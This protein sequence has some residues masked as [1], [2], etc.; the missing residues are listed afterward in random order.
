MKS[1]PILLAVLAALPLGA[2]AQEAQRSIHVHYADLDLS[3][4]AG[5]RTLDHR[6]AWAISALCAEAPGGTGMGQRFA[7]ERCVKAKTAEVA[8]QRE[9]AIA[10]RAAP[11]MLAARTR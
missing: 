7:N 3:T 6:L 11:V 8:P 10:E 5:V 2:H 4:P 1:L 9:R